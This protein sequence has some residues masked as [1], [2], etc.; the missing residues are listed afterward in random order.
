MVEQTASAGVGGARRPARSLK[1]VNVDQNLY[2]LERQV[3]VKLAEAR[4]LS[5]HAALLSS[6]EAPRGCT[7]SSL[8]IR[9]ATWADRRRRHRHLRARGLPT[10]SAP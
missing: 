9:I 7:L 6:V 1:E 2:A 5:A 8:L 4:A 3:E 10:P